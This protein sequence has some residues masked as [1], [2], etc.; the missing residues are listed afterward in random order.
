MIQA[1]V[2]FVGRGNWSEIKFKLNGETF[3]ILYDFGFSISNIHYSREDGSLALYT[4]EHIFRNDPLVN[5]RETKK[6]NSIRI[7]IISHWDLDHYSVL[8]T[9]TN[10]ELYSFDRVF[11]PYAHTSKTSEEV[12]GWL[13]DVL[14]DKFSRVKQGNR[15]E[16]G[17]HIL[18]ES[19]PYPNLET[20]L[21]ELKLFKTTYSQS[22]NN[23]GL[24]FTIKIAN[25]LLMF[26]GDH[27]YLSLK[28]C[29]EYI[30]LNS[31]S[32]IALVVPHHG[33]L[34]GSLKDFLSELKI[35]QIKSVWYLSAGID[36]E[37]LVDISYENDMTSLKNHHPRKSVVDSI[38]VPILR[39]L[40][41]KENTY[42]RTEGK[43]IDIRV[44][45]EGE[46][47]NFKLTLNI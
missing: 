11:A 12:V 8:Q 30:D 17:V 14:R 38:N 41:I 7:L 35:S 18:E 9:L 45:E 3:E 15:Q 39:T 13:S 5:V 26:S 47:E 4:P 37:H 23:G 24:I 25:T 34:A 28:R 20:N 42:L 2:N 29:L 6:Q 31:I 43:H 22:K 40:D 32:Q 36:H 44:N 21:I 27:H 10:E 16:G 33:G 46:I 1:R 19:F